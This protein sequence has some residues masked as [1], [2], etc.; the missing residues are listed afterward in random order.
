[1]IYYT[2]IRPIDGKPRKVI[3]DETGNVVNR[4]P[5]KE[6]LKGL[7]KEVYKQ[8]R[9]NA[10]YTDNELLNL[11]RQFYQETGRIPA[12]RDFLNNPQY[13]GLTTYNNYFGSW[14][15][16]LK[17]VEMDLDA[18]VMQGCLETEIEKARYS[19]M[20]VIDHFK[21]HPVD[22]AGENCLSPCDGICPNGKTYDVKSATLHKKYIYW[23]FN[24][25]NK[26]REEIEI[27][28]FLAFNEDY[29]KLMYVWR[30]LGEIVE[31]DHFYVGMSCRSEFNI[32]NM[33]EYDITNKF[34]ELSRMRDGRMSL[35][36][37]YDGN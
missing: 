11:L 16:A 20:I 24:I 35:L 25:H 33:K 26:Y 17:L 27:Y 32:E 5:S 14:N 2:S 10:R 30:V 12:K 23:L 18:R 22:L 13:P 8:K 1:M 4:S 3:V 36:S 7:E 15:N 21:Q 31:K 6:E 19:E 29:T 28:Y 9:N 34:K 37:W